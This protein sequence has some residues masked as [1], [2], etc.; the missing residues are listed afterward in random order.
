[1]GGNGSG[2]TSAI[3]L[4]IQWPAATNEHGDRML[5]FGSWLV[6]SHGAEAAWFYSGRGGEQG[7]YAVPATATGVR[8]RRWPNEG[9]EAEYVDVLNL[10]GLNELAPAGLDF[11]RPQ[12]FS[13]LELETD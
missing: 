13:L 2:G 7:R 5:W 6:G 1:M 8:I 3:E 9:F 12:R 11:D 4:A 10:A